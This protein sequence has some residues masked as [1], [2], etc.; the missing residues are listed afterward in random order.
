METEDGA[1][2]QLRAFIAQGDFVPN[3]RLPAERQLCDTLGISRAELRKAFNVLE[4]EGAIWRHVGRGTFIGN[5]KEES[6]AMS[7]ANVAKHTNPRDVMSARMILEPQLA[8]EAAFNAT[9]QD[10]ESLR[11][12]ARQTQLATSWREYETLDNQ[13]HWL[14]AKSTQNNALLALF[15]LLNSLRRTVAWGRMRQRRDRPPKD[16]HS[17]AEHDNILDAID[18][19]D[20]VLAQNLMRNHLETV[21]KGLIPS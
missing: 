5:G 18:N 14:I 17:F 6:L 21:L 9:A 12:I 13:L 2:V 11:R 3:E 1:L 7:I 19:R 15:D 4:A 10:M 16:H 20:G 8:R